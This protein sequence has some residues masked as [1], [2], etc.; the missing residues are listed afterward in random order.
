MAKIHGNYCGPNWTAGKAR[1][2]SDIDK[3]PY[4]APTDALDEACMNHDRDCSQ[5]GCSAKGDR[6]LRNAA[7]LVA[8]TNPS[9]RSTALVIAATMGFTSTQ[10]KR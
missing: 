6:A 4:V 8:M 3:L 10:R 1:P 7:F 2:A 9:L 5:G